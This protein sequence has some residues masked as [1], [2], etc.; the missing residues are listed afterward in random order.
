MTSTKLGYGTVRDPVITATGEQSVEIS[1]RKAEKP[2]GGATPGEESQA[3]VAFWRKARESKR[4]RETFLAGESKS[5]WFQTGMGV[6]ERKRRSSTAPRVRER[7]CG[8]GECGRSGR[9]LETFA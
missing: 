8:D 4:G 7:S 2:R 1:T 5:R 3:G 6:G 9:L